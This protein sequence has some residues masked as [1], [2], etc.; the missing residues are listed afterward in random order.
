MLKRN[1]FIE[2][3]WIANEST[4]LKKIAFSH[5]LND[6]NCFYPND[7]MVKKN[8]NHYVYNIRSKGVSY[9]LIHIGRAREGYEYRKQ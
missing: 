2:N 1:S 8:Y 3:A 5:E 4:Y 9:K 7:V 6:W